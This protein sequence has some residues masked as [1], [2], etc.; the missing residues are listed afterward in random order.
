[1]K[2]MDS[3]GI[4]LRDNWRFHLGDIEEA[5]FK[6]FDD[7]GWEEVILPHDWSVSLPFSE[8][9]SSGT[10]YLA[11]GIGWYRVRF[12]LPE[13]YRGKK[14]RLLFDGVYKNS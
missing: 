9:Y 7:S 1:M 8:T 13:E 10:G 6:G 2:Y 5:W 3:V 4:D 14:I 12:S 11:G